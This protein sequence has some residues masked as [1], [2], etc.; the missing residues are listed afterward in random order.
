MVFAGCVHRLA[1]DDDRAQILSGAMESPQFLDNRFLGPVVTFHKYANAI[2]PTFLQSV[3]YAVYSR[4][5]R[6]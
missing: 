6:R 2:Q 3:G 1:A 4:S 5:K